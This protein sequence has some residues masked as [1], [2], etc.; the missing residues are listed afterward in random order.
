MKP[1]KLRILIADDEPKYVRALEVIL[2]GE[3]Y[4]PWWPRM[5]PRLWKRPS[6]TRRS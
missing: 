1:H 6:A 2:K 3:G 5:A 4:E